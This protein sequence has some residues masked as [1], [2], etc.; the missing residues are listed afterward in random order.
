MRSGRSRLR[1]NVSGLAKALFA[2]SLW[3]SIK[4]HCGR[5]G[6]SSSHLAFDADNSVETGSGLRRNDEMECSQPAEPP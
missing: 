4:L 5:P 3:R 6:E 1:E 2:G